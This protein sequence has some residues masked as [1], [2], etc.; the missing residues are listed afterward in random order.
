MDATQD[1]IDSGQLNK[2]F[3]NKSLTSINDIDSPRVNLQQEPMTIEITSVYR[4]DPKT[5]VAS[6]TLEHENMM[7]VEN[8]N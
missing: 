4:S 6:R 5:P 2:N 7:I 3:M 8:K 1:A